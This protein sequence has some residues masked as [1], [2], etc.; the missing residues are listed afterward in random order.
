MKPINRCRATMM[1]QDDLRYPL[2]SC[3]EKKD[4]VSGRMAEGDFPQ[5]FKPLLLDLHPPVGFAPRNA[6][7]RSSFAIAQLS[8]APPRKAPCCRRDCCLTESTLNKGFFC[9]DDPDHLK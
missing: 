9:L 3:M 2:K 7:L 5:V 4:P 6:S 1:L 8:S